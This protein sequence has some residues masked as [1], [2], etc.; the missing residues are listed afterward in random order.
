LLIGNLQHIA[1]FEA[2]GAFDVSTRKMKVLLVNSFDRSGGA[3]VACNRLLQ[4]LHKEGVDVKLLAQEQTK[5]DPLVV[6][7]GEAGKANKTAFGRFLLDRLEVYFQEKDKS[8]RFAFL[9]GAHRYRHQQA[10][11]RAGGRHHSPALGVL[12]LPVH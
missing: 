2:L 4:A 3:A 5:P 7:V 9:A 8:A 1:G 11:G 12:R 6:P 10:P